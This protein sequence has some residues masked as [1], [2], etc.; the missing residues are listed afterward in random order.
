MTDRGL[1]DWLLNRGF[2]TLLILVLVVLGLLLARSR[3]RSRRG[4]NASADRP[5]APHKA[6]IRRHKRPRTRRP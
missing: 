1:A 4:R 6:A 3:R 2:Y 5:P